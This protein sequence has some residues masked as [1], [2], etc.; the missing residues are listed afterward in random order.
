MRRGHFGHSRPFR[1]VFGHNNVEGR[2][3]ATEHREVET[4]S[5]RGKVAA[6]KIGGQGSEK[7]QGKARDFLVFGHS[8]RAIEDTKD[9]KI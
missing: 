4:V 1:P 8:L 5:S 9:R 6:N 7:T 2:N 3:K